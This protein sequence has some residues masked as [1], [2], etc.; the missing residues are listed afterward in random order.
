MFK[1]IFDKNK[2][3]Y[4]ISLITTTLYLV[5]FSLVIWFYLF[6]FKDIN[7]ISLVFL[8]IICSSTD[9]G[10]FVFGKI[11]GG[12]KLT[13]I[14][15]SKTYSGVLGSFLLPTLIGYLFYNNFKELFIFEL[16]VFI[17]IMFISFVSQFGDLVISFLKRKAKIKN[18]GSILPGHGG[19]LDRIDGILLALPLGIF[20]IS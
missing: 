6:T 12:K 10:G 11:I 14:S 20:L 8:L 18:S 19:I 16:N 9:L 3:N 2:L 13:K 15:P 4:F 1:K 17:L 5:Y 7:L